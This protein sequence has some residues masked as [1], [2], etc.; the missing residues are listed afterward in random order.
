MTVK[1]K[2]EEEEYKKRITE[3]NQE[4]KIGQEDEKMETVV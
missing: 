2:E 4:G 1:D 3:N